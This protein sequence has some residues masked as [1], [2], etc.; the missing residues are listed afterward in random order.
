MQAIF[1]HAT[2]LSITP[3]TLTYTV[4]HIPTLSLSISL[5]L[6][7]SLSLFP[8]F[9]LSHRWPI[10]WTISSHTLS[11]HPH[12]PLPLPPLPLLP[13]LPP[14]SGMTPPS[15]PLPLPLL[16][17]QPFRILSLIW[18]ILSLSAGHQWAATI[19]LSQAVDSYNTVSSDIDLTWKF[20]WLILFC[21]FQPSS[22]HVSSSLSLTRSFPLPVYL[23]ICVSI[24]I[25]LS[26]YLSIN[27]FIYLS[28]N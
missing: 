14:L 22:L 10:S 2:S 23:S 21:L 17:T 15:P 20:D 1:V 27:F 19:I 18:T 13:P 6:S 12:H 9:T 16:Y 24:S 3:F 25:H 4:S 28:S 26:I 5:S 8:L 7:P 11:S